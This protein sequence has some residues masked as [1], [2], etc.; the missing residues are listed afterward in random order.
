LNF[1]FDQYSSKAAIV[2]AV[3]NLPKITGSGADIAGA[4]NL[5]ATLFQGC[6]LRS[7]SQCVAMVVY[8]E[9]PDNQDAVD[10]ISSVSYLSLYVAQTYGIQTSEWQR[11]FHFNNIIISIQIMLAL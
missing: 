6:P 8:D 7:N 1:N 9:L 11:Y 2:N 4:M 5:T 10:E 3:M